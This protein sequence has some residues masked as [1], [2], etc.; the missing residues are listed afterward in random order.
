MAEIVP[1]IGLIALAGQ[2]MMPEL[3]R[4]FRSITLMTYG[5]PALEAVYRDMRDNE[6]TMIPAHNAVAPLAIKHDLVFED[7]GYYYEEG[8]KLGLSGITLHIRAGERIGIVGTTGAGKSTLANIVL[9]LISPSEGRMLADGVSITTD[10]ARAWQR[11]LGYVPQ[12]IFLIDARIREN[13]A[14][15]VP[16]RDIDDGKVEAAAR[17][18]KLHDFIMNDLQ[19]GYQTS[20]GE[21]GQRLSGGQRQRIGIA[22]AL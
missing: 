18:A 16:V 7:L 3:A 11:N 14:F 5:R 20:A 21:R 1:T 10:N 22:R 19:D 13:I 9:G 8:K 15:G 6:Q 4:L 17:I 12:E 2:R